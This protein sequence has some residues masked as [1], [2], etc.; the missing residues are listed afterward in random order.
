MNMNAGLDL[1]GERKREQLAREIER[2]RTCMEG[3][4]P[5]AA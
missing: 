5:Q 4:I 1:N 2:S 3:G